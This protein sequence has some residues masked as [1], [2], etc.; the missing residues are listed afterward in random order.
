MIESKGS[1]IPSS[2]MVSPPR[3][4]SQPEESYTIKLLKFEKE[5]LL[6]RKRFVA[7]GARYSYFISEEQEGYYT[8]TARRNWNSHTLNKDSDKLSF[9]EAMDVANKHNGR[10]L[11][12][13]L[14]R[15]K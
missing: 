14:E 4:K 1:Y 3:R 2:P 7:E 5:R 8:V 15:K 6:T 10:M 13:F 11:L 12:P 9:K